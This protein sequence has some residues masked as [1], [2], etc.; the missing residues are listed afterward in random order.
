MRVVGLDAFSTTR[1]IEVRLS[2]DIDVTETYR[3]IADP[4]HAITTST[5]KSEK[6]K[7]ASPV[8]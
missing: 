1:I 8:E 7:C 6:T 4:S 2:S 5:I 3:V